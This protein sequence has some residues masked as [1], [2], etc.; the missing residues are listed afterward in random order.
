MKA[1][2]ILFIVGVA[3]VAAHGGALTPGA[4]ILEPADT[5]VPATVVAS[6]LPGDTNIQCVRIQFDPNLPV[7]WTLLITP[8]V[9]DVTVQRGESTT[10]IAGNEQRIE[11]R[12]LTGNGEPS[13]VFV[14]PTGWTHTAVTSLVQEPGTEPRY[15]CT[16]T[17]Q[18]NPSVATLITIEI[19]EGGE[20]DPGN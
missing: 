6:P 1:F 16:I 3:N 11:K 12:M 19:N 8:E 13:T 20:T 2:A 17:D 7:G 5:F 10:N 14:Y 18:D 4:T 9:Y 15:L